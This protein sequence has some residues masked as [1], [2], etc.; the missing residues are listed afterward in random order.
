MELKKLQDDLIHTLTRLEMHL[1]PTFFD[2]S[3]H[4]VVH[5]VHQIKLVGPIFLHQMFPFERLMSVL[6][7]YIQNRYRPKGCMAEGWSTKEALEFSMQYL[8]H[9]RLGIPVSRHEGRLQGKGVIGE[10]HIHAHE[11]SVLMQAHFT[12]LQQAHVV[13][14]Y[15]EKH[16]EELATANSSTSRHGSTSNIEKVCQMATTTSAG[17]Y[18]R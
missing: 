6:R 2:M 10:K 12:V 15:V 16:K 8:G 7:K 14:P 9:T 11:Y 5:L 18:I 17:G 13:S 3:V 1:P 4:L